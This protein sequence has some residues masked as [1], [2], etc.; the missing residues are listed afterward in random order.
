MPTPDYLLA[1]LDRRSP[2]FSE[3]WNIQLS[4]AECADMIDAAPCVAQLLTDALDR[5]SD[6]DLRDLRT[7]L[8]NV[9]AETSGKDDVVFARSVRRLVNHALCADAARDLAEYR[10]RQARDRA[11]G[12]T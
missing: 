1:A 3:S 4:G 6:D 12:R 10:A 7:E 2:R 8:A 11:E 9:L 5:A